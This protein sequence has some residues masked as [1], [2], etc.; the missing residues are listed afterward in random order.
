MKHSLDRA[1]FYI[2]NVCNYNCEHCNR[3]NNYHFNGHQLWDDYA[4]L[5]SQWGDKLSVGY[6]SILGGEPLLNPSINKWIDGVANIWKGKTLEIV[7]NGT[8]LN[9]VKNLYNTIQAHPN[10]FIHIGLHNRDHLDD[11]IESVKEFL[12]GECIV[13]N[14]YPMD[15]GALWNM[16]YKKIRNDDWPPCETPSDFE[17]LPNYVKEICSENDFDAESFLKFNCITRVIDENN[18][19][20]EIHIEDIFHRS[21]IKRTEST[22]TVHNSNPSN[23]HSICFEKHN[24]HFIRGK[25]YKCNVSGV[26]PDFHKQFHLEMSDSDTKLMNSYKPLMINDSDDVF[27]NFI[28]EIKN[29]I[30]Q[31]KFCPE[32]KLDSFRLSPS[33]T[34][35]KVNKK[36]IKVDTVG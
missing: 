34:K 32:G 15:I 35:I 12:H 2:T 5:Y 20:V 33:T 19:R 18:V 3:F 11:M 24:H 1:E 16:E 36:K 31:C 25:L 28:S 29:E 8:R 17:N 14:I 30:P 23:A 13:R 9:K 22:F 21:A 10:I 7:T 27:S 4:E 26:L 6:I